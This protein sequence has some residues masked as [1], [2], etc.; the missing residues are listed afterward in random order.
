MSGAITQAMQPLQ[1]PERET[2]RA[3]AWR[4]H[5]SVGSAA[6]DPGVT[7]DRT[8]IVGEESRARRVREAL[9]GQIAHS[10]G[11][12]TT[13]S[14]GEAT[15][16]VRE[17][18]FE[19]IVLVAPVPG[20]TLEQALSQLCEADSAEAVPF[21][22]VPHT[23]SET[24]ARD[25]YTRGARGVFAWPHDL[26]VLAHLIESTERELQSDLA[27]EPADP[28]D[29]LESTVQRRL[30]VRLR[31]LARGISVDTTRGTREGIAHLSGRVSS[32]W[33]KLA[34][35]RRAGESP[36]VESVEATELEV[37]GTDRSD[38]AIGREIRA[39]LDGTVTID[40]RTLGVSVLDG[41]V[42]LLGAMLARER[43]H[44]IELI[45]MVPG[46]RS[47]NDQ[48]LRSP[49]K[50]RLAGDLADQLQVELEGSGIDAGLHVAVV[51]SSAVLRGVGS[52]D[53]IQDASGRLRRWIRGSDA[54]RK[55]IQRVGPRLREV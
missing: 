43:S 27:L 23:F 55:V 8:L 32:L 11:I 19:V 6:V 16:W 5:A 54:I 9:E 38:A 49:D 1:A 7:A 12:V 20:A 30:R 14:I 13:V 39:L 15:H 28:S 44:V 17:Q 2:A 4:T 45:S 29:A 18:Q 33:A 35:K 22:L 51:G 48:S 25:L 53:E 3:A 10:R 31:R 36:G 41:R 46:V 50:K 47:V 40:A 21:A 26:G 52:P 37:E 42:V 34:L 24:R